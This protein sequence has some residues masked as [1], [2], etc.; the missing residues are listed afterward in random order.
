MANQFTAEQIHN[1][2]RLVRAQVFIEATEDQ[3]RK[4]NVRL[5]ECLQMRT[6]SVNM[7]AK[8]DRAMNNND[9]SQQRMKEW[10]KERRD[11]EMTIV[12]ATELCN[13]ITV[14]EDKLLDSLIRAKKLVE[15]L[16]GVQ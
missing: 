8:A 1:Q 2:Q 11:L 7:L 6:A 4:N 10:L 3:L 15:Q 13:N 5:S 12:R 14:L 16:E 9:V